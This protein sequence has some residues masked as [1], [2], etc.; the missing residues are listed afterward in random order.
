MFTLFGV[1]A[2]LVAAV[3]LYSVISYGVAQ[4]THELGVRV[5]LGAQVRDVVGLVVGEGMRLALLAVVLGI[6]GSLIAA[7]WIAPLL[8][9]TSPRDPVVYGTVAA[10]LVM[11]ALAASLVP[12]L[13]ASRVDPNAALRS[14]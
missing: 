9:A 13:R 2:L 3:G 4:R 12:A 6:G 7:R 5:A 14:D 1:L 8:F 10:V 11:I